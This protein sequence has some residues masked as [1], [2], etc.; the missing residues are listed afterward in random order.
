LTMARCYARRRGVLHGD[1]DDVAQ[2]TFM[3]VLLNRNVDL[4]YRNAFRTWAVKCASWH[5]IRNVLGIPR[6]GRFRLRSMM[7]PLVED[8][9]AKPAPKLEDSEIIENLLARMRPRDR[10]MVVMLSEGMAL[11]E[12]GKE[13]GVSRQRVFQRIQRARE[14]AL[15]DDQSR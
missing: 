13:F 10:T 5:A 1:T 7:K 8:P 15:S 4:S 3:L 12:I 9:P 6:L 11:G 14:E 2:E